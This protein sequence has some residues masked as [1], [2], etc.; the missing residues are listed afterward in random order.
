[1]NKQNEASIFEIGDIASSEYFTGKVKAKVLLSDDQ[2]FQCNIYNVVFEKGARTNWHT[3]PSGQ[4]LLVVDGIGF[5]Q[6]KGES[7]E[8]MKKGDVITFEPNVEHW[9]GASLDSAMTHI[10]INPNTEKGLVIWLKKVTDE[11][12]TTTKI[13]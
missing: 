12:F 9:H 3:H 7:V 10:A 2:F 1:M 5:Y 11:E 4:I 6:R 8:T 13:A